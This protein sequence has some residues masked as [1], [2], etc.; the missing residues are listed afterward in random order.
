LVLPLGPPDD[1]DSGRRGG[2]PNLGGLPPYEPFNAAAKADSAG[3][4]DTGA[5]EPSKSLVGVCMP[6]FCCVPSCEGV[7]IC[8]TCGVPDGIGEPNR[9]FEEARL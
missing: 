9:A 6:E 1:G 5:F 7:G 2:V 8:R 4:L 3:T